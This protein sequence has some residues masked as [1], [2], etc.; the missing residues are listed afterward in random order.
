M[1][2]IFSF[3]FALTCFVAHA[4]TN[5]YK[6]AWNALNKNDRTA[7]GEL[8]QKAMSV[9]VTAGDAF[10]TNIYLQTYNGRQAGI[11]DFESQFYRKAG[12]PY[13]YIYALWFNKAVLG[14]YGRKTYP[15]QLSLMDKLL[16]DKKAPGTLVA[17]ANYQ[18][19]LHLVFSGEVEKSAPY[20]EAVG[21]IQNWQLTG[22]F[23]NL[24]GSGFYKECGPEQHPEP[25]A[26]FKSLSNAEVKWFTPSDEIKEGWIVLSNN[27]DKSTAVVYAQSFVQSP[28]DQTV[29]CNAGFSGA[30]KVWIND[31]L[32]IAES[33]EL[34]TE[35][36]A[37]SAEYN[38]KRGTNRV[39]VQLSYT[40]MGSPNFSIRITDKNYHPIPNL[41]GSN[42][43]SSY[44]KNTS[45]KKHY[46]ALPHFTETWFLKKIKED[47]LNLVNYLLLSDF[48]S[49][50][51]QLIEG[52]DIITKALDI[53]PS[54][55]LLRSKLLELLNQENN[56]TLYLE[57]FEKLK[58][59]DPTGLMVL[60]T[61]VN[62]LYQNQ[63]Y[64]ECETILR[65]IIGLYGEDE[66][67]EGHQ[68]LLTIADQKY[69]DMVKLAESLYKKY[70]TNPWMLDAMYNI[71]KE[72]Y[73][74][75]K[76]ALNIYDRFAKNEFNYDIYNKY[77][78]ALIETGD[79]KKGLAIKERI[80]R[81][82]PYSPDMSYNLAKY[83]YT[84]K[85]PQKSEEYLKRILALSPYA[86]KYWELSGDIQR[87][88]NNKTGALNAYHRS[89]ELNPNQYSLISKIRKLNDK[90][91]IS[92]LFENEDVLKIIEN[93]NPREAKNTEYG[94]Y[95][96][97]DKQDVVL[98]PGGARESFVTLLIKITNEKG[99][100]NYKERSIYY[101]N[102]ETLLIENA[103]IIKP[104]QSKIDGEKNGN[105]I[106]FPNL[107]V[108][109]VVYMR[110]KLQSYATGR[111]SREFWDK[112]HFNGQLY[113]AKVSYNLLAPAGQQ[114]FYQLTENDLKP[115]V[116]NVE[117]FKMYSWVMD[118]APVLK[119]EPLMPLMND[120]ASVLHISTIGSWHEIAD[121][122]G[123]ALT[124]KSEENMEIMAVYK[125]LFGNNDQQLSEY[126]KAKLIYDYIASN[127]KYSSVPFRQGP[128]I[129]QRASATLTTK[130]G[131]CKDLSNLFV[132]LA[133]M[134]GINAQL[135]LVD[136]RDNGQKDLVMP[137]MAFNHCIAK[138]ILD[139]KPY[140]IELTDNYLPFGSLPYSI[141]Y[142]K[143][144]EIPSRSLTQKTSL[145][146]LKPVNRTKDVV[147][148]K[149]NITPDEDD[150]KITEV[151][152]KKG[153][154][155]SGMRSHFRNQSAEQQKKDM[156][157]TLGGAYKNGV[158]L[159]HIQFSDLEH[160]TDSVTYSMDY[161]V[162]NE[163][164]EI[165]SL[166][167]FKIHY[168]D[169]IATL[170]NFS[171][172]QREYPVEYWNYETIDDYETMVIM[173]APDKAQFT[174]VPNDVSLE[175]QNMKYSIRYY[176]KGAGRL[177]VIRRFS[178]DRPQL[179]MP[180]D[181][182][183]FKAFF[184][185]ITKA[186]Q[187]FIAYK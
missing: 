122:Y 132:T 180:E 39:L 50:N 46:T 108:G 93:D 19:V 154:A 4:Q 18:K 155:T 37:R 81:Q 98:Y 169:V 51:R 53:A 82:F 121:W 105:Q 124:N 97:L 36:D 174:E 20:G 60:Q 11:K 142:A 59:D 38:L 146:Q 44:P 143:I 118:K 173:Q 92:T 55:G 112:H 123:D 106:V 25:G 72:V 75:Q 164:N 103:Q 68:L 162:K 96:I 158:R 22:P 65:K 149:I 80:S 24:S 168:P 179:I 131:D 30:I 40:N 166:K 23:E 64:Q 71:Q 137:S 57:E 27:F 153:A 66:Y 58:K 17:A 83:Y 109:D 167:T 6:E 181:Y 130:L 170:D 182:P 140:Y 34:T 156:E 128:L 84:T 9:E 76:A 5:F 56:R 150:L 100:E 165:G 41:R 152:I 35:L 145:I 175:F 119:D 172:D 159:H 13:P 21:T 77:A 90:P 7:A 43:A 31:E 117:D 12:N 63:K 88:K 151:V 148:R 114:I 33:K 102:A 8:L 95:Y 120:V 54:N 183:A 29:I 47:S 16:T 141:N 135:V 79:L 62:E 139:N 42:I 74:N 177:E 99:I 67:T 125:N 49:R 138:A 85:Q 184:E 160:L 186:E 115:T 104:N 111:L 86:E 32:V 129:P 113:S 136:T 89:L 176:K 15:W 144:L 70:P 157:Q 94:I 171:S 101:G 73:Q 91:E 178:N 14:A 28:E 133:H 1:K 126:Q 26:V 185:K 45:D 52:R 116:S 61:Q 2:P 10:I 127:I 78:D 147:K 134:A 3:A 48:Y 69:D 161:S 163:V 187:K 110:Y 87:E 107:E